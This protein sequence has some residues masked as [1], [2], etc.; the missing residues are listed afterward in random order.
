MGLSILV[1]ALWSIDGL[2]ERA[3]VLFVS[4]T[5]T[6]SCQRLYDLQVA[7]TGRLTTILAEIYFLEYELFSS[8][9]FGQVTTDGQMESDAYEPTVHM[10][11]CAQK[12]QHTTILNAL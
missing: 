7:K 1:H 2:K 8:L 9:N 3:L 12:D 11:R 6:P 10:H 4:N 5:T